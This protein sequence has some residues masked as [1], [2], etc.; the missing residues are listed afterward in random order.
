MLLITTNNTLLITTNNRLLIKSNH[1][2]FSSI[3]IKPISDTFTFIYS[4]LNQL[5][6][7]NVFVQIMI[8]NRI[9]LRLLDLNHLEEWL[10]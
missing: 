8:L 10:V 3:L 9:H 7:N 2:Y 1:N 5:V 4:R 6:F